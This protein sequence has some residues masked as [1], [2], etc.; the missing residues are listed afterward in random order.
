VINLRRHSSWF[1]GSLASAS[2]SHPCQGI[3]G[4]IA[5]APT[6]SA[7]HQPTTAYAPATTEANA[8]KPSV[9]WDG[10]LVESRPPLDRGH[11]R[12]QWA[13]RAVALRCSDPGRGPDI[14]QGSDGINA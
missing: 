9:E 5:S 2:V 12:L 8:S 6:G 1:A 11:M 3:T 4:N 10:C 7:D 13:A 14:Q